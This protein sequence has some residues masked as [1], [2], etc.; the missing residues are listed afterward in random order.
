MTYFP[1]LRRQYILWRLAHCGEVSRP[2][3]ARTFSVSVSIATQDIAA[4]IREYPDGIE[5][6]ATDRRYVPGQL[7]PSAGDKLVRIAEALG[8]S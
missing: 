2:D 4:V 7:P 5:Y 3:I 8:W 6:D 1:A